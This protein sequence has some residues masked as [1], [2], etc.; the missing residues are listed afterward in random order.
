[1]PTF[2]VFFHDDLFF[3]QTKCNTLVFVCVCVCAR[4]RATHVRPARQQ[5]QVVGQGHG[6]GSRPGSSISGALFRKAQRPWA[7][8]CRAA[9]SA[10]PFSAG[11][12]YRSTP[13]APNAL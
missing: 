1:M 4:A 10:H 7:T 6:W 11:P 12:D 9:A 5:Q 3:A 2:W 8:T 13:W